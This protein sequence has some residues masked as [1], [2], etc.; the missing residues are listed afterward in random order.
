M[1]AGIIGTGFRISFNLLGSMR[2]GFALC[3]NCTHWNDGLAVN[4]NVER[5]VGNQVHKGPPGHKRHHY[6]HV[7]TQD[8]DFFANTHELHEMGVPKLPPDSDLPS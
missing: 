5:T 7:A 6:L 3:Q 2:V 1:L 8:K 4:V